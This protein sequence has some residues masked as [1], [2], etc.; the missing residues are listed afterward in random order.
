MAFID[1][2][3]RPIKSDMNGDDLRSLIKTLSQGNVGK[4]TTKSESIPQD[5]AIEEVRDI[6]KKY[7]KDY[8]KDE[9]ESQKYMEQVI[10]LL[11]KIEKDKDAKKDKINMPKPKTEE[12]MAKDIGSLAK[13]FTKKGS[14]Y[15]HDVH[16]EAAIYK[17]IGVLQNIESCVCNR[18]NIDRIVNPS[19]A[20]YNNLRKTTEKTTHGTEPEINLNNSKEKSSWF[21]KFFGHFFRDT[22]KIL[23]SIKIRTKADLKTLTD[24]VKKLDK[25]ARIKKLGEDHY[26]VIT[27]ASSKNIK[28]GLKGANFDSTTESTHFSHRSPTMLAIE[29]MQLELGRI[30]KLTDSIQQSLFGFNVGEKA[31]KGVMKNSNEYMT[32]IHDVALQ[33]AG[34]T[35]D[36]RTLQERMENIDRLSESVANTGFERV[37]TQRQ[38][39]RNLRLG[40]RNE[41]TALRLGEAQLSTERLI[42]AEA[43]SLGDMFA[44]WFNSTRLTANQIA[45]IGRSIVDVSRYTGITGDNLV[46]VVQ[47][48]E[49]FLN[50]MRGAGTFSADAARNIIGIQANAQRLGAT[51]AIAPLLRGLSSANGFWLDINEG[52]RSFLAMSAGAVNNPDVMRRLQAGTIMQDTSGETQ[53]ALVAGMRETFRRLV[54]VSIED[55]NAGNVT[56]EQRIRGGHA[57]RQMGFEEPGDAARA[58]ASFGNQFRSLTEQINDNNEALRINNNLQRR[59]TNDNAERTR[60]ETEQRRL[61]ISASLSLLDALEEETLNTNN[62]ADALNSFGNRSP[63]FADTMRSLGINPGGNTR[64]AIET[65]LRSAIQEI[66][67]EID[68][69]NA[70]PGAVQRERLQV[71]END[72]TSALQSTQ[73][74]QSLLERITTAQQRAGVATAQN[75]D[76][77]RQIL[78]QAIITNDWLSKLWEKFKQWVEGTPW[79]RELMSTFAKIEIAL[80]GLGSVLGGILTVVGG[81]AGVAQIARWLGIGGGASAGATSIGSAIATVAVPLIV[82]AVIAGLAVWVGSQFNDL[83]NTVRDTE[84]AQLEASIRE[85]EQRNIQQ[86]L[87]DRNNPNLD[88][89]MRPRFIPGREGF[90]TG[91]WQFPPE[92]GWNSV[93]PN[94]PGFPS[95]NPNFQQVPSPVSFMG[96][97]EDVEDLVARNSL[98][99]SSEDGGD[100]SS[101]GDIASNSMSTS[102]GVRRTNILLQQIINLLSNSSFSSEDNSTDSNVLNTPPRWFRMNT[103]G[104]HQTANI[105]SVL[106]T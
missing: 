75:V 6:L 38:Y 66:N 71:N 81:I 31:L 60:L 61:R 14:G 48:S 59:T 47:S 91:N 67:N 57:L 52:M 33:T 27:E 79:V 80:T 89:N 99:V 82:T 102:Q 3:G 98:N 64:Q 41:M 76:S 73:S 30:Q 7:S 10:D 44:N 26:K 45:I 95:V 93:I 8:E 70:R 17:A 15:T 83:V 63:Q 2:F 106:S 62:M 42:G 43:G 68:R 84:R 50:Q 72:I 5:K 36:M 104:H 51:Q 55:F 12:G 88:Q 92:G 46:K 39:I 32:N 19:Q 23:Y 25:N 18:K 77:G 35:G 29:L 9:K 97:N 24:V 53:R 49:Q 86:E 21:S 69:A 96:N 58:I 103:G 34:I 28:S 101:L 78:D 22:S 54:G 20:K 56:N 94:G 85:R 87:Q 40:I 4:P 90:S 13:V 100:L 37:Q 1:S 11:K 74:F 105:A 65:A 16:V